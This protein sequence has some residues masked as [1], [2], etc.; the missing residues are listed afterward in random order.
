[1]KVALQR[2]ECGF[3][4]ILSG[5]RKRGKKKINEVAA[6]REIVTRVDEE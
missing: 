3:Y 6:K 2:C 4:K 5:L 1:M